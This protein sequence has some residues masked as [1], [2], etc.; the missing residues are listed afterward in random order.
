MAVS[1]VASGTG[2]AEYDNISTLWFLARF[3][4]GLSIIAKT[5]RERI[6]RPDVARRKQAEVDERRTPRRLIA[7]GQ[8][9]GHAEKADDHRVGPFFGPLLPVEASLFVLVVQFGEVIGDFYRA[10]APDRPK[11]KPERKLHHLFPS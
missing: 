10:G 9:L 2:T 3:V 7:A 5:S 4:A 1:F 8:G 6:V 11:Q